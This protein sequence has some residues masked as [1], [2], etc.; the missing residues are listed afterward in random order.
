[1]ENELGEKTTRMS[2]GDTSFDMKNIPSALIPIYHDC[3]FD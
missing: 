1:M 3:S 2:N